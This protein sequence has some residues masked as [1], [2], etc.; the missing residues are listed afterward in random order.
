MQRR[1]ALDYAALDLALRIRLGVPLDEIHA[2]DD[3]PV[4][5][6]HDLEHASALA[7]V[8]TGDDHDVVVAAYRCC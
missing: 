1:L 6:R 3:E 2:L 4:L 7:P 5:R 8:L